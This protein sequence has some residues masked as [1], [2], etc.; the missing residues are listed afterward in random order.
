MKRICDRGKGDVPHK[1]LDYYPQFCNLN[2]SQTRRADVPA[3]TDMLIT[4]FKTNEL[5][6]FGL[7]NYVIMY[8]N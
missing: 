5:N 3:T 8:N 1:H 6:S 2:C 4:D 7:N